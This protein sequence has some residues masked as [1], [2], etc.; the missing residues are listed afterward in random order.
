MR[1]AIRETWGTVGEIEESRIE[2]VF[3]IGKEDGAVERDDAEG[4]RALRSILNNR[5]KMGSTSGEAQ[6]KMTNIKTF[7][8]DQEAELFQDILQIN[9]EENEN[10]LIAKVLQLF[11]E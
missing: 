8:I 6:E 3:V 10:N 7:D 11:I 9:L 1:Q 2:I 4:G 5:S